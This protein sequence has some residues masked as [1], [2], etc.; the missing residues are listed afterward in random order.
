[1]LLRQLV[2]QLLGPTAVLQDVCPLHAELDALKPGRL[3]LCEPAALQQHCLLASNVP[4][5]W[6]QHESTHCGTCTTFMNDTKSSPSTEKFEGRAR[7]LPL[8]PLRPPG[9]ASLHCRTPGLYIERP[10]SPH[11]GF[12][13]LILSDTT[14]LRSINWEIPNSSFVVLENT[15]FDN[16]LTY[17]QLWSAVVAACCQSEFCS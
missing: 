17:H 15:L 4:S 14:R 6:F 13:N 3:C 1:M 9:W 8:A 2:R 11:Q 16:N 12:K 5:S 7:K 10:L